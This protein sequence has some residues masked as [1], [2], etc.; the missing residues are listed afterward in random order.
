[1]VKQY[2]QNT[3][4]LYCFSKTFHCAKA[5][6]R[7]RNSE[8]QLPRPRAGLQLSHL[9]L[10]TVQSHSWIHTTY[11]RFAHSHTA[12]VAMLLPTKAKP[13]CLPTN[14]NCASPWLAGWL[15]GSRRNAIVRCFLPSFLIDDDDEEEKRK[16]K[17]EK[18]KEKREKRKETKRSKMKNEAKR[19]LFQDVGSSTLGHEPSWNVSSSA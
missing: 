19:G 10:F 2:H 4:V 8:L 9:L 3:C 18:R 14:A 17:R 7:M 5:G 12:S 1:M 11:T 15:A 16:E 6:F 13:W